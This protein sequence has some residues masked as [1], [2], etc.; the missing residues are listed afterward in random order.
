M[1]PSLNHPAPP[2]HK[3]ESPHK[4]P[5]Q[6]HPHTPPPRGNCGS[7]VIENRSVLTATAVTDMLY[8]EPHRVAMITRC[9]Q[10]NITGEDLT[11]EFDT[12]GGYCI[13]KGKIG[14]LS[15][16]ENTEREPRNIFAKL[17]R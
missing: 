6:H 11:T 13:V 14:S 10:L 5:H 3:P 8:F 7:L 4:P 12:E 17:F 1:T 2:P 16:G 9:G 15:Y